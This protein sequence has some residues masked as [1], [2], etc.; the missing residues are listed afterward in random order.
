LARIEAEQVEAGETQRRTR[1]TAQ[2]LRERLQAGRGR[3]AALHTLQEAALGRSEGGLGDWLRDQGLAAAPRLAECLEVDSGWEAAV[4]T[5]LAGYLDAV[6]VPSLDEP[7]QAATALAHGHLTLFEAS[8]VS[9]AETRQ[10]PTELADR[11]HAPWPLTELL[12]GVQTATQ[13][14]KRWRVVL[15]CAKVKRW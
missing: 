3:L 15:S 5:V 12:L 2:T 14:R 8:S 11:I 7:A 13:L 6:C 1:L 4:E 9:A 10:R